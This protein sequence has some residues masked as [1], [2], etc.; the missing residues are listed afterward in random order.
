MRVSVLSAVVLTGL[1]LA[2][3]EDG[4]SN[5]GSKNSVETSPEPI[6]SP[7][8]PRQPASSWTTACDTP[9]GSAT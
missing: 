3:C 9:R 6:A 5:N 8:P 1:A 4:G 7:T 2:G